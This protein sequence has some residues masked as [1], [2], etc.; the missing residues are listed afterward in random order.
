MF[1]KALYVAVVIAAIFVGYKGWGEHQALA[2]MR[3]APQGQAVG[4]AEDEAD[5]VIVEFMDYRCHA[6]RAMHDEMEELA[7]RYPKVRIVFRHLP[8]FG[9]PSI[10][11][12]EFVLAAG[13]QGQFK[14]AHDLLITRVAPISDVEIR[15]IS[16]DMTLDY[17]QLLLD[18][19]GPETGETLLRTLDATA[20]LGIKSTP[21]FI[22]GKTVY[23]PTNGLPTVDDLE[24]MIVEK[25]R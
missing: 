24:R 6:C 10:K 22:I 4:P 23:T 5:L 9:K 18:M 3:E 16:E 14:T 13:M 21:S 8:V 1:L 11:E 12:A 19:K 7:S 25:T 17:D 20:A 2:A 15:R